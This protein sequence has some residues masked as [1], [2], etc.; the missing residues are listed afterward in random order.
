[1]K[2]HI[3]SGAVVYFDDGRIKKFLIMCRKESDSWHLPK[4]TQNDGETLE[5]TALREVKEETGLDVSLGKYIGKLDSSYERDGQIIQKETNYFLATPLGS[6]QINNKHDSEH[7]EIAFFD[8]ATALNHLENFSLYEK[9]GEIL[10]M[11]EQLLRHI[12]D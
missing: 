8:Y 3:S 9:E 7:D 10:K 4:G 12:P 2:K 6:P 1:M 11:A 5:Q